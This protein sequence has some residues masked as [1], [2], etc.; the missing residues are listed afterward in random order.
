MSRSKLDITQIAQST[1]D[2]DTEAVR[3]IMMPTEI[4]IEG[5]SIIV[6]EA[7]GIVSCKGM[8][9]VCL[10][11]TGTVSISPSDVGTGMQTLVLTALVPATICARTIQIVGT[12]T[13]VVQSV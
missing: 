11:G 10:Y 12:G 4:E 3:M 5:E 7:D 8:R 2:S 6:I 1:Y 13:L 9:T